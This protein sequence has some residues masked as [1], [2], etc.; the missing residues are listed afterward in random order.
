MEIRATRMP[1][2]GTKKEARA[3][4][5]SDLRQDGE[6]IIASEVRHAFSSSFVGASPL[7]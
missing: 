5:Q 7:L 3:P 1:D 2:L 6:H 4:R